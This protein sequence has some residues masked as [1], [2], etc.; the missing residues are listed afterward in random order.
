MSGLKGDWERRVLVK[1]WS[2]KG[3]GGGNRVVVKKVYVEKSTMLY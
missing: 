3:W 2:K 1:G